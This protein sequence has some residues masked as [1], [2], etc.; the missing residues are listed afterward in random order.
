MATTAA[1]K[2]EKANTSSADV[3]AQ[4]AQVRDDIATLAKSIASLGATKKS[5]LKMDARRRLDSISAASDDALKSLNRQIGAIEKEISGHVRERP[6][7]TLGIAAGV[8]FLL[9]MVLRR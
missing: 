5:E 9:A 4:I 6:L 7:Q 3:E 2:T 1:S 8:G